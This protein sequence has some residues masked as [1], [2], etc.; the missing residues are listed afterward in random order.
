MTVVVVVFSLCCVA[1]EILVPQPEIE[2][3]PPAVE[4]ES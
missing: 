3:A 4:A 1:C 2:P